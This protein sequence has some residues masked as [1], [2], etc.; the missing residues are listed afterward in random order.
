MYYLVHIFYYVNQTSTG[1]R[2][3]LFRLVPE[4]SNDFT[5]GN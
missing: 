1:T 3:V 2:S 5:F 4:G